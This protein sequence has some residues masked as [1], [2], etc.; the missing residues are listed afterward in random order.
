MFNKLFRF[1]S[2][3]QIL[4]STA[5]GTQLHKTLGRWE[6][7]ALGIGAIIGAGIFVITG[8]AASGDVTTAG[9]I[10]R[11]PAGPAITLSFIITAVGCAFCALCYAELASMIPIA[12]SAYTYS[13]VSM[14]EL[15]AWI[16]GWCLL[17]EYIFDAAT[18]SI[19][20][21][22]YLQ[23]VLEHVLHLQLPTWLTT[24]T[25]A[26]LGDP[27]AHPGLPRL[28]GHPL[29]INI[30]PMVIVGLLTAV[31]V[32]GV[33]ESTR[34]NNVI[35]ALKLLIVCIFIGVGAFY[36]KPENWSPYMPYGFRGVMAG[37]SLIFFAYIGFDAL[38]TTSEEVRDPGRDLPFGIIGSLVV[39]TVFYIIVSAILTGMVPYQTLDVPDPVATALSA[40][41]QSWLASYIVSVGAVVALT[42]TMLVF[43]LGLPRIIFAMARDGFFPK[44]LAKVHRHRRTPYRA[45]I[46]AGIV[47]M[48]LA[49]M[50]NLSSVAALCNA[51]TLTAFIIVCLSVIVL[52][53]RHPQHQ[54]RFRVPLVPL[55][56]ILGM[57]TCGALFTALPRAAHI[58]F[59]VW[60][61]AGLIIYFLYGIRHTKYQ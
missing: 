56:P 41:G 55:V 7:I 39:C 23:Q 32:R 10:I 61:A 17:L 52:R 12:G 24:S 6:L 57:I 33:R 53:R 36:V 19:G 38:S 47:V 51:G 42:S 26:A 45:T 49:G 15:V 13:Y 21:A 50:G 59:L 29:A 25:F 35:V 4:S 37:A 22:G 40:V 18:V 27:A 28:L 30:L 14:G 46:L 1:K 8:T 11:A 60:T 31:L 3:E 48:L 43:L 5:S 44:G 9:E 58:T 16:V 20:W 34:F 54:R 2:T